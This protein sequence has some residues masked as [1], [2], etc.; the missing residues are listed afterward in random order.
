[1]TKCIVLL[2][3]ICCFN[4]NA[5]EI[6]GNGDTIIQTVPKQY[7]LIKGKWGA[8]GFLGI[9]S[10]YYDNKTTQWIPNHG[11][12]CFDLGITFLSY[13]LIGEFRPWT[14]N[15]N[16]DIVFGND[17]LFHYWQFNDIKLDLILTYEKYVLPKLSLEP[18]L[19][20]NGSFFVFLDEKEAK[21]DISIP[22]ATGFI[23]G[24]Y[25]NLI[26]YKDIRFTVPVRLGIRYCIVN[27]STV[28][29]EL[30]RN[31]W[32]WDIS[33]GMKEKALKIE[34]IQAQ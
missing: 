12:P 27:M 21:K 33:I 4:I 22:T 24:N 28:N 16:S 32:A 14:L 17:T 30:G 5:D 9:N 18:F 31:Y 20:I 7:R 13:A 19:G 10:L 29:P 8:E 11:G 6:N 2:F 15:G 26:I 23:V 3:T 34:P 25:V 1:M